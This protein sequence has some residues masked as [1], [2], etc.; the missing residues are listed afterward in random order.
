MIKDMTKGSPG[1]DL[2]LF[3][4]PM[5]FGNIFQQAY[6]IIDS[7]IVGNYVGSEALASIGASYP[8]TFI[9]IT[10]ANGAGIGSSVV[11]SQYFGA[12]KYSKVKSSI[13]TSLI[14]II[15]I[16]SIILLLGYVFA[17]NILLFMN[18]PENI[19]YDAESYL[20]IYFLGTVFLFV[21]NIVNSSFNAL[22][23]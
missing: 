19:F 6:S 5:I 15:F 17:K 11:I 12:N 7:I 9:S 20:K 13:Y 18:T 16:S 22:G 10:I 14:S 23:D 2:F 4:L 3:A 21:Y 1:K 8:I